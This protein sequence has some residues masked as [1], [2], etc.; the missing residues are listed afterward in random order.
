MELLKDL[1]P[2]LVFLAI[3]LCVVIQYLAHNNKSGKQK[4]KSPPEAAAGW[5]ILGHLHIFSGSKLAHV[6]LGNM[7]DKYGPAFTIRIGVH[8]ALVV[9]DWKLVKELSTVHDVHV[10]S[11]P[12]FRAAEHLG[13]NYIMFA[14]TPYGQYW[15]DIR[16]FVSTELL[17]NRRLEQRKHIRVSE[18]DTS[19]KELYKLW[20][21]N[22][23]FGDPSG[24]VLVEMKK[25]FGDITVNVFLQMMAGKRYFR[26]ATVSDERDGRRC[27]K[28]LR[29]FFHYLGVFAPADALPFLG[30]L[31]I[32]G[33]EKTMKEVAKEM[34]SLVDDWL[35]EHRRKK[36]AAGDGSNGG[37]E[38]FIDAM[39]SRLEEI[40]RNGYNADSVIKSTCM[41]LIAGGADTVTVM[42]TWALSLMMNNPHVL[43][44]AQEELDRIVGR[45]RK[46]N[47]SDI[48][49]LIYLQAIIKETFRIYPAA[50]LGGP[51]KFTEDC[52]VSG[53]HVP[54]G[55][56]LFFNV[57]KLQRD[58][59]VWSNPHEFK[60]ERF[61]NSHKDL[62]VLGQDFEL[63][64][65]GAG[66]RICPGTTFGLQM[67]HLVL[68][69]LLRSFEL[70][71]ISDE[72]IDMTETAGLTNLKLTPLEI[73][74]A[75]RLP[76]HLY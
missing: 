1:Y 20:T 32:G 36:V 9:S 66:R 61:I 50:P 64:P 62:D 18:I 49:N 22:K 15:R 65:F 42:L 74:I 35:Q 34:D 57:W 26:T 23:N 33:Y 27:K 60:P 56:W 40:D 12:K 11:R 45:E 51:R 38:D 19:I 29:D 71:N 68:A 58:P 55:T 76:P 13:Y 46:V 17:S 69:S 21:E 14:F 43:K 70:S 28:A 48:N 16:K 52:N 8:R 59:Q 54:K 75:P 10:S 72:E 37:E 31:D 30:G 63:I 44:M 2:S 3:V 47:E 7:A 73:L 6:E 53:F 67:L 39:L 4:Q 41:N 25:W 5:P 24:R